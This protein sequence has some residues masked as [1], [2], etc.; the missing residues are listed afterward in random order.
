MNSAE[1]LIV[2]TQF[3]ITSC[4]FFCLLLLETPGFKWHEYVAY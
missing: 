2:S 4:L 1:G 3:I